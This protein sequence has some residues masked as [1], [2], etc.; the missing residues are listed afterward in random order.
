MKGPVGLVRSDKMGEYENLG[1]IYEWSEAG[2]YLTID[3]V[4]FR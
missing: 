1:P 2:A 3:R 4:S